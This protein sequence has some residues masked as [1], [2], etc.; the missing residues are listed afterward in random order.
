MHKHYTRYV[1]Q[2]GEI[3]RNQSTQIAIA[4]RRSTFQ[5]LGYKPIASDDPR[6]GYQPGCQLDPERFHFCRD[7]NITFAFPGNIIEA[8]QKPR[9]SPFPSS[10]LIS[11]VTT[12]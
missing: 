7:L 10:T 9:G 3:A 4:Y 5:R 2:I 6:P 1:K 12:I 8:K 11:Y